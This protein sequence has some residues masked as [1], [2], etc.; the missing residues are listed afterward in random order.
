LEGEKMSEKVSY[1]SNVE[2]ENTCERCK[3]YENGWCDIFNCPS[4]AS[5]FF[6]C[7]EFKLK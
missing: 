1:Y 7:E 5:K 6:H 3:Y 2:Q 4:E